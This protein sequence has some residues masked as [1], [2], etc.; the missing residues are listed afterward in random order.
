MTK[1]CFIKGIASF[2]TVFREV[3][4]PKTTQDVWFNLL[5]DLSDDEFEYAVMKI[6]RE[7]KEFYPTTNFVALIRD[8]VTVKIQDMAIFA[9]DAVVK[10]MAQRGAYSSVMFDDPVIHSVVGIMGG[11]SEF[12]HIPLDQWMRKNFVENY[13]ALA[14]KPYHPKYLM[15][16]IEIENRARGYLDHIP[17][18]KV[19][20]TG[21]VKQKKLLSGTNKMLTDNELTR[22][23]TGGV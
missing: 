13:I 2:I 23:C 12:C 16:I 1:K 10:A 20:I 17:K 14:K 7:V 18:M 5:K 22:G 21:N 4:V 6:C 9:W 8:Q 11:W 15:G 3:K 19:I